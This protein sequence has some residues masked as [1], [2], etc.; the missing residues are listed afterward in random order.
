LKHKSFFFFEIQQKYFS[1][2]VLPFCV[3]VL[4]LALLFTNGIA[5]C[6]WILSVQQPCHRSSHAYG[7]TVRDNRP[8]HDRNYIDNQVS[9]LLTYLCENAFN[10]TITQRD[11]LHPTSKKFGEV[12]NFLFRKIDPSFRF[13][14]NLVNDVHTMFKGLAYP[15][16]ISKT[17]LSAVGSA[18]AWP[19][20]LASLTWLVDL[21]NYDTKATELQAKQQ[22][23]DVNAM[24]FDYLCSAYDHFMAN[25]DEKY[26]E[27]DDEL[28]ETFRQRDNEIILETQN[29]VAKN[30]QLR[31]ELQELQAAASSLPGLQE[32]HQ[33]YADDLIKFDEHLMKMSKVKENHQQKMN[34]NETKLSNK[35]DKLMK[36]ETTR[37]ELKEQLRT[38][39]L[40]AQDV[41]RISQDRSRLRMEMSSAEE[42]KEGLHSKMWDIEQKGNELM[43]ALQQLIRQY[44]ELGT[45]IKLLPLTAKNALG[46]NYEVSIT[47][48]D[49]HEL[50]KSSLNTNVLNMDVKKTMKSVIMNVSEKYKQKL[51]NT[52]S[53][54]LELNE[55]MHTVNETKQEIQD[56]INEFNNNISKMEE[57]IEKEKETTEMSVQQKNKE[58]ELCEELIYKL[59]HEPSPN[60]SSL[61]NELREVKAQ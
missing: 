42:V 34:T 4:A 52:R 27:L 7:P 41:E 31:Q 6:G 48:N 55:S 8:I 16:Q 20:L 18:H 10:N 44:T 12:V 57:L 13:Q 56:Q 21:I 39:D 54:A 33:T 49:F 45:S 46:N 37:N 61:R 17:S 26:A 9:F 3:A 24:F 25:D 47:S 11:L 35:R 50:M 59:R 32:K 51:T 1:P 60:M 36:L 2:T 53:V 29:I 15:V 58:T 43:S 38:Q 28:A 14:K 30:E 5:L 19:T 40:S 23:D 22:R